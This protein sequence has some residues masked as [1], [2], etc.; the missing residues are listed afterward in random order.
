[1]KNGPL[2]LADYGAWVVTCKSSH[3]VVEDELGE[4]YRYLSV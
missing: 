1:M 2:V 3:L 4:I